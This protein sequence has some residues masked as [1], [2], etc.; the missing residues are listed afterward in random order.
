VVVPKREEAM[1]RRRALA[2]QKQ[3]KLKGDVD[4]YV[5]GT[6]QKIAE[7]KKAAHAEGRAV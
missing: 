6:M 2:L 3:G 1:L 7:R 5:F 4:A